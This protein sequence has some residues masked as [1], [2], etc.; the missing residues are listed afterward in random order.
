MKILHIG[1]YYPP[2]YGGIENFLRDLAESQSQQGHQVRILC[3]QHQ[4]NLS[5]AQEEQNNI[6]VVRTGIL[7]VLAYT[8][9]APSYFARLRDILRVFAPDIVHIHMPNTSAFWLLLSSCQARI[10]IHWHADVMTSSHDLLLP[11]LY[12]VYSLFEK[13]LLSLAHEIIVS[14]NSYL[15]T[16]RPL[17]EY[18]EKCSVVPL[19]VSHHRMKDLQSSDGSGICRKS[20]TSGHDEKDLQ[21][22]IHG[23]GAG[24][25][26]LSVGRFT[27]Y[28]GFEFLIRAAQDI[29]W[30][31][32]VIAGHGPLWAQ[33]VAL[34]DSL[35]LKATVVL[36][37]EVDDAT[38][39]DLLEVSDLFCLPSVERTE[40]FGLVLLEAMYHSKPLITTNVRGSGMN[41]V[42]IHGQTGLV[43]EPR[44]VSLLAQGIKTI[45]SNPSLQE[46]FGRKSLQRLQT[47][48]SLEK[49][50]QEIETIYSRG[51]HLAS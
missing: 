49:V 28:K 29:P 16:S 8:P 30:A 19:A 23:S 14:S 46:I 40:A 35:H 26:V 22:L 33:M 27:H 32:F 7:G 38:L 31:T 37:G 42:N 10:I 34:R 3:H 21:R 51:E 5:T 47:H 11:I 13:R 41:E 24:Y 18:Q 17:Q 4:R 25:L 2:A 50:T 36:P 15:Q 20:N 43:V 39:F 1:K 45:L 6:P 48:F 44:S 12:P 9:L